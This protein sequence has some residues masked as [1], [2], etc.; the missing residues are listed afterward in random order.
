M[1]CRKII[2]LAVLVLGLSS[3]IPLY[4]LASVYTWTGASG[5][6]DNWNTTGNWNPSSSFP[7]SYSDQA[8]IA[9]VST[10]PTV[11]ITNGTT[12]LLGNSSGNALTINAK[13]PNSGSAVNALDIASGGLLG[14]QGSISI[15]TRRTITI[16]G[17]L[18]NDSTTG[19][20]YNVTGTTI[21]QGGTLASQNGGTWSLPNGISG[22]GTISAPVTTAG[23]ISNNVANQTLHITG[24]VTTSA[25]RGL[26]GTSTFA[27]GALLSIEGGHITGSNSSAGI[28]NYNAVNL[29][30][31]FNSITLY[32][33]GGYNQGTP[34]DYNYYNLT[35]DSSWNNGALNIMKFNG[36]KLDVTGTVTNFASSGNGVV[37]GNGTLNNP[38][39]TL[40]TIGNGNTITLAGGSIT[41]TANS[42]GFAF[43]TNLRGYGS[44]STP[45]TILANGSLAVSGG[46]MAINNTTLNNVGGATI[47]IAA[48]S[49][50]QV[51]N[52]TVNW[53]NF[54]NNGAYISDPST[55]TFDVLTVAAGGYIQASAGDKYKIQS[56]FINN[57]TQNILWNTNAAELDLITK[58]TTTTH[59]M[60]LAGADFGQNILGFTNNF[61]WGTLDLTGQTL[62]L[63]DGNTTTLG[64]ALYVGKILGL[65]ISDLLVTDI[66]SSN[67]LN[68]YYLPDFNPDLDGLTYNLENGGILAPVSSVPEPSTILIW[69]LLGAVSWIGIRVSR[70]KRGR[71]K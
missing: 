19:A 1:N 56:N 9:Y 30:G 4:S 41:G 8:T 34:G 65:N 62:T 53:G 69:S 33:D 26:G 11:T 45:V 15:G 46:T 14:M 10:H 40:T 52:S 55:Q 28:T 17:T 59:A 3:L 38:G 21:L 25:Q 16:E 12:V 66:S 67:G 51:N 49:T 60:A 42:S 43:G 70:R 36:Y 39:T 48:G 37:V 13:N 5:T 29:R 2:I 7:N 23:I 50:M 61:A 57:S 58:G 6:N 68:I 54:T 32:N 63:S 47:G 71:G 18:R 44:I 31:S 20:T 24:D 35:G 64:G 22:Y 27:S